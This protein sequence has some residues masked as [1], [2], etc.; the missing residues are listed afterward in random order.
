MP[1]SLQAKAG[2]KEIVLSLK[3]EDRGLAEKLA[4]VKLAELYAKWN[5]VA[6]PADAQTFLGELSLYR[7]DNAALIR[8]AAKA[9]YELHRKNLALKRHQMAEAT[10]EDFAIYKA[11]RENR[12]H[13]TPR[14]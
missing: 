6:Q 14:D 4:T 1:I 9:G 5:H 3:T 2:K 8:E 10:Q 7:P 12:S 13:G 11:K